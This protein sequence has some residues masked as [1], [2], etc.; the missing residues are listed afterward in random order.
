[1]AVALQQTIA[2][3]ACPQVHDAVDGSRNP[4]AQ[5]LETTGQPVAPPGIDAGTESQDTAK[6]ATSAEDRTT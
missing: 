4:Q 5:H 1:M 2:V 3:L 6:T